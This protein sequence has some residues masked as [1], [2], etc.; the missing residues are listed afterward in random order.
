MH[1]ILDFLTGPA[2]RFSLALLALGSARL[3]I[4]TAADIISIVRHAGN[5]KIEYGEALAST[6][7][8]TAPVGHIAGTRPV[9]SAVS[10]L[11]HLGLIITPLFLLEHVML[12][13]RGTGYGWTALPGGVADGLTLL[14]I[15]AG[16][17]LV[18]Y[19]AADRRRRFISGPSH[20][21]LTGLVVTVFASGFLAHQPWSPLARTTMMVI[22]A[23]A[24]NVLLI[25]IPFTRLS[26]AILFPLARIAT[27][28][29]WHFRGGPPQ[30]SFS[31]TRETEADRQ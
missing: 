17:F 1:D 3:L 10:F 22:H 26:H 8:W 11:F 9:F 24:G 7:S 6:L 4:L 14:V 23:L 28:T 30:S 18:T 27:A 13:E 16:I 31:E 20:Y 2:A 29:A 25:A 15:L 5:K 21:I 12:W 19:R